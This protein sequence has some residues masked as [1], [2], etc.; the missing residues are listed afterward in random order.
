MTCR[1]GIGVKNV[2]SNPKMIIIPGKLIV[3]VLNCNQEPV[4]SVVH[5]P[6]VH[7]TWLYK[8]VHAMM[9]FYD[10]YISECDKVLRAE[11]WVLVCQMKK[12]LMAWLQYS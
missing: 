1:L 2:L 10:I 8:F 5:Y 6:P 7:C 3:I 4:L 11:I 12:H 9:R